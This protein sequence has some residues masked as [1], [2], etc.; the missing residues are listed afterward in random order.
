[1]P[2]PHRNPGPPETGILPSEFGGASDGWINMKASEVHKMS[3]QELPVELESLRKKLFELKSQAIT[4]KLEEPH[5][6]GQIKRDIARILTELK[7]RQTAT[8]KAGA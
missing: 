1:M 8:V 3:A 2:N 4:Q 7:Q 5:R 6:L